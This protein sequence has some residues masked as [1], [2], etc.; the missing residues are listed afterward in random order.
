V[1][2]LPQL[3]VQKYHFQMIYAN[4][5]TARVLRENLWI[6]TEAILYDNHQIKVVGRF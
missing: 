1:S 4:E 6:E 5:N 3:S 2:L